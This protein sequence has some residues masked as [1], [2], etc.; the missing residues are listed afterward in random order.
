MIFIGR[1]LLLRKLSAMRFGE[2]LCSL[3]Y[4]CMRSRCWRLMRG[5]FFNARDTVAT[6]TF[7]S[8]AISFIVIDAI[9]PIFKFSFAAKKRASFCV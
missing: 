2:K 1:T 7:N 5:L 4:A 3:A 8:L 9:S 6:E